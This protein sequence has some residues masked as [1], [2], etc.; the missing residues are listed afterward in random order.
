MY[1]I[2]SKHVYRLITCKLFTSRITNLN[3]A[4]FAFKIAINKELEI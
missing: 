1:C 4:T 2:V 3:C